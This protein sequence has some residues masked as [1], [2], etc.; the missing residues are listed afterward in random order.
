MKLNRHMRRALLVLGIVGLA[1]RVFATDVREY[2][3]ATPPVVMYQYTRNT[4]ELFCNDGDFAI[5]VGHYFTTGNGTIIAYPHDNAQPGSNI[6][7]LDK[8]R[9]GVVGYQINVQN[10]EPT[11]VLFD[12]IQCLHLQGQA[13]ER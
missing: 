6:P 10:D 12:Y 2:I 5:S 3:Q 1:S 8:D 4:Q 11:D 13:Q 7:I 9:D